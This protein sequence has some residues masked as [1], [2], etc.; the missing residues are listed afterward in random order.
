MSTTGSSTVVTAGSIFQVE[1]L[2]TA[3][4]TLIAGNWA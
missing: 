2:G 3:T 1:K 4:T